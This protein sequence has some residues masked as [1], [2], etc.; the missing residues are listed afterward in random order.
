M[1]TFKG[2]TVPLPEKEPFDKACQDVR[3]RLNNA[4]PLTVHYDPATDILTVDGLRFS[5]AYFRAYALEPV[6]SVLRIEKR[7]EDGAITIR[8]LERP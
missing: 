2:P 6:G 7:D 8:I 3:D 1:R 5:G 4:V